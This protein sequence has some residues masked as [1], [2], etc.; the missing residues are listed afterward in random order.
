MAI[1]VVPRTPSQCVARSGRST[2]KTSAI[3]NGAPATSH[4]HQPAL[5]RICPCRAQSASRATGPRRPASARSPLRTGRFA[6]G[7]LTVATTI[8]IATATHDA[9]G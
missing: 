3:R 7:Q 4:G 8:P 9:A 2:R 5:P 1:T 6:S